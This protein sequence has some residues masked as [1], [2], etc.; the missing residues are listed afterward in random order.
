MN[1]VT[2]SSYRMCNKCT[3]YKGSFDHVR[4]KSLESND[5]IIIFE[6][7]SERSLL[8]SHEA[9]HATVTHGR[10]LLKSYKVHCTEMT[11][12]RLVQ[13]CTCLG[14]V[15]REFSW[16]VRMLK[17]HADAICI[18]HIKRTVLQSHAGAIGWNHM[19]CTALEWHDSTLHFMWFK[20]PLYHHA[21]CPW[22]SK[23]FEQMLLG[24]V[25]GFCKHFGETKCKR[26]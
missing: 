1:V 19:K 4:L 13:K 12:G 26:E 14:Y 16:T 5:F 10:I 9:C 20:L 7:S 22:R 15:G 21:F 3:F 8:Q 6:H 11:W 23:Q 25:I 18:K 24:V 2:T 17:S